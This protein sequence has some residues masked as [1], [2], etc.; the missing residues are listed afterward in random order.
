MINQPFMNHY[1][2]AV[3]IALLLV[4]GA[5]CA[6]SPANVTPVVSFSGPNGNTPYAGL[7]QSTDGNF[8]GTTYRGGA[9]GFPFGLGTVFKLTTNGLL[10]T[11]ASFNATNGAKPFAGLI[12]HPDGNLYG[13]TSE[14]GTNGIGTIFRITTNGL[15]TSLYSFTTNS[16]GNPSARLTLGSDG[17]L[18]GTAQLG[19]SK[20]QGTIFRTTT[21]GSLTILV[22]LGDT[23]GSV[24]YAELLQATDGHLYGTTT[25]G[26]AW[27]LG[28]VFRVTTS[29][30]FTVLMSFD[31]T[32]GAKPYGGLIQE[33][34]G[35]LYGTTTYGGPNDSG[36][37][38]RI[39]TNGSFQTLHY[40][41]GDPDGAYPRATLL[42]GNDGFLYGTTILGGTSDI[43]GAWGT[44]F[45]ISTNGLFASLATFHFDANGISPYGGIVQDASG[46][47]YTTTSSQ[48]TGLRGTV[49]RLNP[50]QPF[51]EASRG[52]ANTLRVAWNAW[53]GKSYQLQSTTNLSPPNWSDLGNVFT[54][55]NSQIA[56]T[57]STLPGSSR[58][59]RVK[60]LLPSP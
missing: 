31:G 15:L 27:N 5:M 60:L 22:S 56:I 42:R 24:P 54:A 28:T 45:Q 3:V 36:T 19:G 55:T 25:A 49:V 46:S 20:D 13:N 58:F 48:G 11:L 59:H 7:L 44:V 37:V 32:N 12:Q 4:P 34:G 17:A 14:G 18:Y 23:N 26:G 35:S 2:R 53:L 29:G 1:L 33:T 41:M 51:L 43:N 9:F 21:N 50:G 8:Y 47:L 52:S 39:T 38:F 16:G 10:T 40:F 30:A 6:Q 57:N